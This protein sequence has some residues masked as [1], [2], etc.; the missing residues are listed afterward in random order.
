MLLTNLHHLAELLQVSGY[1]VQE[2]EF[3]KVLGSLVRH[4]HHLMVTLEQSSLAQTLPAVFVVQS[5]GCLKSNLR[6]TKIG[7]KKLN[8][9]TTSNL[10]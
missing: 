8:S 5:A 6:Q 3:I 4:L 10:G 7:G 9:K 1:E 2:G